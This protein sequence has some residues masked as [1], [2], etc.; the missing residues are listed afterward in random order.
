MSRCV[1]RAVDTTADDTLSGR[2]CVRL[3]K[4]VQVM[5]AKLSELMTHDAS[6]LPT[7][8]QDSAPEPVDAASFAL[9]AWLVSRRC[10]SR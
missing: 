4:C 8:S 5:V 6:T 3:T 9:K 7:F 1:P 10:E 2:P